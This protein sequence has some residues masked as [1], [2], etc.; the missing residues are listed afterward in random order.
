MNILLGDFN[1]KLGT[2]V[3]FESL[4]EISIDSEFNRERSKVCS[5]RTQVGVSYFTVDV[6]G[7]NPDRDTVC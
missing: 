4:H 6:P 3:R 7:S 5:N 1:A 2:A